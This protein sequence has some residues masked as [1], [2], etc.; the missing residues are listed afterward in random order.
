LL[1]AVSPLFAAKSNL[2]RF[3][4]GQN[5]EQIF[6]SIIVRDLE[7]SSVAINLPSAGEISFKGKSTR[8]EA[9]ALDLELREDIK[10]VTLKWEISAR[11]DKWGTAVFMVLNKLNQHRWD[12]LVM[13]PKKYKSVMDKDW[14]RE[15]QK[16]EPEEELPYG[17]DHE[18]YMQSLTSKNKKKLLGKFGTVVVNP[19][20]PW[21]TLCKSQ[22]DA[23]AKAAKLAKSR[24]KKDDRWKKVA[25]TV[26]DAR[27]ERKLAKEIG[28]KCE[29]SCEYKVFTDPTEEPS[30]M[31]SKW[32]DN[33]LLNEVQKFL[34]PA[35]VVL[36]SG[37]HVNEMK[38]RNVTCFGRFA[39]DSSPEYAL[40]RR[41][42]H[43]MR[44]ELFFAVVFGAASPAVELWPQK[45]TSPFKFEG[46]WSDNG[47]MLHN[48]IKPRAIPILQEYDWQLRETYEKLALPLAKIFYDD[49]DANPSFDKVVRH[50]V[51]RVAKKYIGKIAF[52]EL[53]R[54]TYSY[55][56][57]DF[58]LN[59]PEVYPAFGIS[60]NASYNAVKYGYEITI[61]IAESAQAFWKDADKASEKLTQFCEEVLAGSWPEA[62]ESAAPQ[63]AWKKGQVRKLVWKSY[64][65]V[66]RP[67]KPFLLEVYGKYRENHDGKLKETEHLATA[68]E[69]HSDAF[70][71]ASYDTSEN[72]FPKADFFN[73]EKYA[74]DAEWYWV[75]AKGAADSE[76]PPIK[77]LMK[78]KKNVPVKKILE[79][80]AEQVG[81]SFS[82][83]EA[84]VSYEKLLKDDPIVTTT[85]MPH[86]HTMDGDAPPATNPEGADPGF[87]MEVLGE[88]L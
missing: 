57:R 74:S 78:P 8:G 80:V 81:A 40:F 28:A 9:Y 83:D 20:Y 68:L 32:S 61:D 64:K 15:D 7:A 46:S 77:K 59:Q 82:A 41:V 18:E 6:L 86:T 60:S 22:D 33:E 11:S 13:D 48:W 66:L 65:E 5:K 45:Q 56:L 19:R 70:T 43:M 63:T 31:K 4:W 3:K 25:F 10:D 50:A 37:D 72:Y 49:K 84:H 24:G 62:H 42:A 35:V 17:E 76:R 71:V 85:M 73:R 52:V 47:T 87:S 44:G 26:L 54:S 88:E 58:G 14:S 55:E 12:L 27:E 23:F 30:I 79:F 36:Q 69:P 39:S 16:L 29:M 67:E 34:N 21:C 38:E 1:L 53:K 2:P 75:P 51:R